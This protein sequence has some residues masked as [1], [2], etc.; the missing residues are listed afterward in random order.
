[1]LWFLTSTVGA[2]VGGVF[3]GVASAVGGVGQTVASAAA[4][5]VAEANPLDAIEAQVR[6]TGTDPEAPNARPSMLCAS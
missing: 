3:S 6:A 4:P 5:I 1:M 2:L